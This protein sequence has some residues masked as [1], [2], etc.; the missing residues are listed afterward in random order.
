MKQILSYTIALAF[1]S[2]LLAA[3]TVGGGGPPAL[4]QLESEPLSAGT[5]GLFTDE[6]GQLGLG[7]RGEIGEEIRLSADG[8]SGFKINKG[9]LKKLGDHSVQTLE[10]LSLGNSETLR[11][12]QVRAG[13]AADELILHDRRELIRRSVKK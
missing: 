7:V 2:V 5:A 8:V 3:G 10:A 4:T 11:S 6:R 1:H 9:D 13:D 12:Y